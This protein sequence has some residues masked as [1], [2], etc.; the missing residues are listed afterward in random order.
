MAAPAAL[1]CD[2]QIHETNSADGINARHC[3]DD[4]VEYREARGL[5]RPAG[6][7]FGRQYQRILDSRASHTFHRAKRFCLLMHSATSLML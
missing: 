6:C 4:A 2:T 1:N 3:C 5:L 7:E